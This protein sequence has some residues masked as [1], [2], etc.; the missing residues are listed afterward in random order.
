MSHSICAE[1]ATFFTPHTPLKNQLT[2]NVNMNELIS[3]IRNRVI[4]LRTRIILPG[5]QV[6]FFCAFSSSKRCRNTSEQA[7]APT[8]Q[9][10]QGNFSRINVVTRGHDG[11]KEKKE[12]KSR[13]HDEI[14][15]E[16][17]RYALEI[18][19]NHLIA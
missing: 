13:I 2:P 1:A 3:G 9:E 19:W 16:Y 6:Q 11:N 5:G 4:K 14:Y 12:E 8:H 10:E 15:Q 17:I 7:H 18:G